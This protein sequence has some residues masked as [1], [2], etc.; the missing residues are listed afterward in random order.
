VFYDIFVGEDRDVIDDRDYLDDLLFLLLIDETG[1]L[2][3]TESI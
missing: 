2:L 1:V 3:L